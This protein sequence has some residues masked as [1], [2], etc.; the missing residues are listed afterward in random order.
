M[1]N[2][3]RITFTD[4]RED[5]DEARFFEAVV[6][7]PGARDEM[8]RLLESFIDYDRADNCFCHSYKPALADC[9]LQLGLV[10]A[11]FLPVVSEYLYALDNDHNGSFVGEGDG[12]Y[13]LQCRHEQKPRWQAFYES[14]PYYECYEEEEWDD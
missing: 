1:P 2:R 14:R 9:A 12:L 6:D 7:L 13:Q 5:W 8:A 3:L 10:D 4:G 11:H